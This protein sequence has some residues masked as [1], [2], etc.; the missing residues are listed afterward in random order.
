MYAML[1]CFGFASIFRDQDR[2][3]I[4]HIEKYTLHIMHSFFVV[5]VDNNQ[6]TISSH[7]M[8]NFK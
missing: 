1:H 2:R 8:F 6:D 4:A 7:S 5:V 3:D